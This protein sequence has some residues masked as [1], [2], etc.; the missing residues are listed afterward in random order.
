MSIFLN[1]LLDSATNKNFKRPRP[2][3]ILGYSTKS[4]ILPDSELVE[5]N[6]NEAVVVD[7]SEEGHRLLEKY[8]LDNKDLDQRAFSTFSVSKVSPLKI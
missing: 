8:S 5:A 2:K 4:F 3:S 6:R 7:V 1:P